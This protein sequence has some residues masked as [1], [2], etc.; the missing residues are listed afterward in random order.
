MPQTPSDQ[1]PPHLLR[2]RGQT[3][4]SIGP[5][6]RNITGFK[7]R[8][9][10]VAWDDRYILVRYGK[11]VIA[12]NRVAPVY[13]QFKLHRFG[14]KQEV[15]AKLSS[16]IREKQSVSKGY[17]R[18]TNGV[19]LKPVDEIDSFDKRVTVKADQ[20]RK[21]KQSPEI[22]I[23]Y[24]HANKRTVFPIVRRL[25]S[26]KLDVWIDGDDMLTDGQPFGVQIQK[27][28][29]NAKA[30]VVMISNQSNQSNW[31]A[32][33]ATYARKFGKKLIPFYLQPIKAVGVLGL[34]LEGTSKIRGYG[35]YR[36]SGINSLISSLI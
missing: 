16:L 32:L 8:L 29:K 18:I 10:N 12:N 13:L 26:S 27:A 30:V 2:K 11:S 4:V 31:V 14:S 19:S 23:S 20:R 5:E 15:D 1:I 33:E 21:R 9:W 17:Q 22:F 36:E 7:S 25:E 3:Y 35:Q 24:A 6:P 28:V 34:Q